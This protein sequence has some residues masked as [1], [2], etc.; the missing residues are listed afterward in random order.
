MYYRN[1]SNFTIC[2]LNGTSP[3]GNKTVIFTIN[4]KNY[5]KIT[6]NDGFASLTINLNPGNYTITTTYNESVVSVD[7]NV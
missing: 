7:N 1:G 5:T 3:L 6:D 4:G 2:L